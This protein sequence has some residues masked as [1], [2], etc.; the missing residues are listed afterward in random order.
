MVVKSEKMKIEKTHP[1][2]RFCIFSPKGYFRNL[3]WTAV[4]FIALVAF[5]CFLRNVTMILQTRQPWFL[6]VA[7]V[8]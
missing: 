8:S 2:L 1:P 5:L 6:L 7:K 3:F 4:A